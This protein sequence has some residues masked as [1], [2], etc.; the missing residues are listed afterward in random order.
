M[1][2]KVARFGDKTRSRIDKWLTLHRVEPS[3]TW[4]TSAPG[5]FDTT[6]PVHLSVKSDAG[7]ETYELVV[8]PETREVRGRNHESETF[9]A[10][11]RDW[12]RTL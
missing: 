3:L 11:V 12:A 6:V 9:L 2:V 8:N 1:V 5:F 4:S 10:E 7:T